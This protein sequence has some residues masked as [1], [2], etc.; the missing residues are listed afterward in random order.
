MRMWGGVLGVVLAG[1]A[2]AGVRAAD[3]AVVATTDFGSGSLAV[4]DL[5]T[6][7]A[8][9]NLLNIHSDAVVRA[10][11]G[12]VYVVNRQGQDNILVLDPD[13]PGNPVLQFSTGNGSNPQDIAFVSDTKAYVARLASDRVLVVNPATGDSLGSIDLSF[14]A[15]ADGLP[16]AAHLA[17]FDGRLY[18]TCQRL[19]QN[20]LQPTDRSE[21]V[22]VDT[23]TDTVI[24]QD[25][26]QAG[27]QGIV[28][29]AT[30]P[31]A[32]QVQVGAK[33]Y[34]SCAGSVND[35]ADGG[36]EVVDLQN[37]RTDGVVMGESDL[38]GNIGALAMVSENRR[39]VFEQRQGV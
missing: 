3:R 20:S 37:N 12:K 7:E 39:L 16:E 30:N 29:Q 28:L 31:F 19:D 2:S 25:A 24:D 34:L 15:D 17:I 5:E 6:Y 1:L 35:M 27:L 38:G 14:A 13:D 23:D 21:V 8:A 18:V 4:V 10:Y 33:L 9:T 32:G 11:S 26:E 22:V 36:I